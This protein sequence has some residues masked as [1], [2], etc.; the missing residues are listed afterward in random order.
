MKI[1]RD[2]RLHAEIL[3]ELANDAP[4]LQA[5]LLYVAQEWLTL[6][7]LREQLNARADRTADKPPVQH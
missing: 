5:P 3:I 2:C 4:A 1:V 6:A 7:I